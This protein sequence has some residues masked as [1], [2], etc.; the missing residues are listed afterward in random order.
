[1]KIIATPI[2]WAIDSFGHALEAIHNLFFPV[3]NP[4]VSW[5]DFLYRLRPED[6]RNVQSFCARLGA[7][8]KKVPLAVAAIGSTLSNE[9]AYYRDIDLLLLPLHPHNIGFAEMSFGE[10]VA[11]QPESS[12]EDAP[13]CYSSIRSWKLNFEQG[14]A[15]L[16]IQIITSTDPAREYPR[17]TLDSFRAW[18][19]NRSPAWP[20]EKFSIRIIGLTPTTKE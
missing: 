13:Y 17:Q 14:D 4:E 19:K 16:H 8:D 2:F 20:Y 11:S 1:M 5:T 3:K 9:K 10:F 18:Q 7:L 6:A 15:P 12:T